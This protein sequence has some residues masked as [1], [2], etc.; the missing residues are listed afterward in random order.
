MFLSGQY[1]LI[2]ERLLF[3]KSHVPQNK[4]NICKSDRIHRCIFFPVEGA[5]CI[6]LHT[7]SIMKVRFELA[8]DMKVKYRL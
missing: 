1:I 8:Q 7:T 4:A 2:C 6:T 5:V 3:K